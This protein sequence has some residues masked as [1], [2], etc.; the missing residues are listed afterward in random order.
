MN[1]TPNHAHLDSKQAPPT[2]NRR[3]FL[4]LV[5]G[6][7]GALGLGAIGATQGM[8]GL[9]LRQKLTGPDFNEQEITKVATILDTAR[10]QF[11][12][13]K[14]GHI[15]LPFYTDAEGDIRMQTVG[16]STID[17]W[18]C[19]DSSVELAE[20]LHKA[21]FSSGVALCRDELK[22]FGTHF[23]PYIEKNNTRFSVDITPPY[24]HH[25]PQFHAS[26]LGHA[27]DNAHAYS[28]SAPLKT[29]RILQ[30][31]HG[32]KG[33]SIIS[34]NIYSADYLEKPDDQ[35][36]RG[37]LF[38][39]SFDQGPVPGTPIHTEGGS[40]RTYVSVIEF[41]ISPDSDGPVFTKKNEYAF[42]FDE[43]GSR[44]IPVNA[45]FQVSPLDDDIFNK[46]QEVGTRF[47]TKMRHQLKR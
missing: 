10:S 11:P 47:S 30:K 38:S 22:L 14:Y 29:K 27:V 2:G 23:F 28:P 1:R 34:R 44:L 4:K 33:P 6:G 20:A 21:G 32:K 35:G 8:F 24:Y 5:A 26:T 16:T 39:V 15:N 37:F 7:I 41:A 25:N 18:D 31:E 19:F 45:E 9:R 43:E 13:N 42:E 17:G 36:M 46:A 40:I 3:E 12:L